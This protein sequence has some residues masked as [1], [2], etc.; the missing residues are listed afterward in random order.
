MKYRNLAIALIIALTITPGC[1]KSEPSLIG[2][3]QAPTY[4]TVTFYQD[5]TLSILHEGKKFPGR[6]TLLP[7]K[8]ILIETAFSNEYSSCVFLDENTLLVGPKKGPMGEYR[9]ITH[10]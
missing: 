1:K 9:R 7:D 10:K 5:G 4:Q 2:D 8:N 3:W 6:Y